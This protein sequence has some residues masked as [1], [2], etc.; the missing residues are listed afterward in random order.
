MAMT[1]PKLR[2]VPLR[3]AIDGLTKA[4]RLTVTMSVGQWDML[5]AS[6]YEVGALLLELDDDELPVAAYQ[7]AEE[8]EPEESEDDPSFNPRD[9]ADALGDTLKELQDSGTDSNVLLDGLC[10]FIGRVVASMV[11]V[12]DFDAE[13]MRTDTLAQMFQMA[14]EVQRALT[15]RPKPS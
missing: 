10:V 12:G 8:G 7:L 11:P 9:V 4:G 1:R 15:S 6:A 13:E 14:G 5:L 2:A 3:A